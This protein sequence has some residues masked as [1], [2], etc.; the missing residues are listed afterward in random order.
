[1]PLIIHDPSQPQSHGMRTRSLVESVD[2]MPSLAALAGLPSAV[3]VPAL[4]GVDGRSLAPLFMNRSAAVRTAA[5]SQYPRCH[6]SS[7]SQ[8]DCA[9]VQAAEFSHMGLTVRTDGWRLIQWWRW[10]ADR[11]CW[12]DAGA[13]VGEELYEQS[14][15]GDRYFELLTPRNQ[16]SEPA[17]APTKA[18]LAA[19]IRAH[20]GP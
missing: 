15:E 19:Q 7:A 13:L 5:F 8:Q 2:L 9:G 18:A 14:E 6:N 20:F 4:S 1:M 11:V 17:Q 16:A 10:C 12:E 3:T